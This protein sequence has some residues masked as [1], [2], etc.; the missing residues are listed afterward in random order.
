MEQI[1]VVHYV[2]QFFGQIGGEEMAG[3]PPQIRPGPVGPG[4]LLQERL[5]EGFPIVATVICGDNT[6]AEN[7]EAVAHQLTEL[8]APYKPQILIAG[9][10]FNSGRYGQSCAQLCV[11]VQQ[12]LRI[13]AIT[14][15]YDENPGV[16]FRSK[17]LIVRTGPNARH[18]R[19]AI[20][21]M[22][23]LAARLGRGEGIERPAEAGC[24]ARGLKRSVLCE[25][26]AA[27]RAVD[28]LLCKIAGK[29]FKTE[30]S[31]PAF[32]R[33]TPVKM[34]I[35]LAQATV[36]LVTDG[37]LVVK[38]NPDRMPAGNTDRM[39]SVPIAGLDRLT[40]E[41]VEIYHGGFD[42]QF[43][44]EDPERLVPL[45]AMRDL[46]REGAIGKL[47]ETIYATA[48]LSMSIT[49]AKRVGQE[50]AKRLLRE[51]VQAAILTST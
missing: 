6:F 7:P 42:N 17:T 48:G 13:P 27:R 30:I 44:N 20:E 50:I 47:F 34:A 14:G 21:L 43:V 23:P 10:A 8:I 22:A 25:Y 46:E 4:R 24:F 51:G 19:E 1:R 28:M 38:G 9:P 3:A 32:D 49:N 11:A 5:G 29:P 39:T 2:N 12:E 45:E 40:R 33:V 41:Q 15:M 36:A 37:G 26:N 16:E 18:M 31:I 35:P